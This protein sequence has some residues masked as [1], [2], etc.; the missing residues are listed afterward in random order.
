MEI[1]NSGDAVY[2]VMLMSFNIV[3][4]PDD[5]LRIEIPPNVMRDMER[6]VRRIED[7][8]PS[9]YMGLEKALERGPP[10]FWE[11]RVVKKILK[12]LDDPGKSY[13]IG[14]LFQPVMFIGDDI[15][16][17]S[18]AVLTT[19]IR[20]L[21]PTKCVVL[22]FPATAL[23]SDSMLRGA[24]VH[25]LAHCVV[26]ELDEWDIYK[27][28]VMLTNL[29]PDL[30][31]APELLPKDMIDTIAEYLKQNRV[32]VIAPKTVKAVAT[33]FARDPGYARQILDKS[34]MIQ[35]KPSASW[36]G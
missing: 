25:E 5:L 1:N 24:F 10:G 28:G 8:L 20:V 27:V 4:D 32:P 34:V 16:I 11:L 23:L 26:E 36:K 31:L 12:F 6:V 2:K 17:V 14:V 22:I 29:V 3:T 19:P 13:L 33:R 7:L 9:I 15:R 35:L 21:G 30:F 18:M